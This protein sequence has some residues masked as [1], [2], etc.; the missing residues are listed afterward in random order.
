MSVIR[1][2]C[3]SLNLICEPVDMTSHPDPESTQGMTARIR[4]LPCTLLL[5]LSAGCGSGAEPAQTTERTAD[6]QTQDVPDLPA[7]SDAESGD[8]QPQPRKDEATDLQSVS[9]S[10]MTP[11]AATVRK[12]ITSAQLVLGDPVVNSVDMMLVAI[13][14]GEFQMGSPNSDS[15]AEDNETPQHQVKI[16]KPFYLGVYEVTQSQYERVMESR[17]WQGSN[18]EEAQGRIHVREDPDYPATCLSHDEAVEFCRRLSTLEGVEYRLPTE[19]EWEYACRAGTTTT[20][21]FG[22][23]ASTLEQYAWYDRN[24]WNTGERYAHRVGRT[25]PNFWSL[26]DMHGNVFEWC[27]DWYAPYGS[28][29]ALSD[30]LGPRLGKSRVQRG[31]AFGGNP[32][33]VRSAVRY[34]ARSAYRHSATGFRVARTYH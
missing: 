28:E 31:G 26:Y 13:P 6:A 22:D 27:R 11:D 1:V 16:T 4:V 25:R 20:Y 5:F 33:N 12:Q 8:N 30:P 32:S 19:A 2:V 3:P 17:P 34:F 15:S 10:A 14:A 7:E 9:S 23:D 18:L 24:A 21:S 29:K